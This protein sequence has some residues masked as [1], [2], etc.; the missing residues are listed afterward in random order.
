MKSPLNLDKERGIFFINKARS[1]LMKLAYNSKIDIIEDN[2]SPSNLGARKGK[3]PRD[4]IFVINSVIQDDI[5][6]VTWIHLTT[7]W[8]ITTYLYFPH[9][10]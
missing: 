3:S 8:L 10:L 9:T 6:P 2:L 4:H 7:T 1:I 5:S